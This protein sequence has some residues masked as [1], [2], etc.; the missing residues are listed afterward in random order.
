[1]GYSFRY[2]TIL[3]RWPGRLFMAKLVWQQE[4]REDADVI[5]YHGK[6]GSI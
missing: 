1:V 3:A 2:D 4:R 6:I 5:A